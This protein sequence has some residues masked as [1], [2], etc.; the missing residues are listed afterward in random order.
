MAEIIILEVLYNICSF[1]TYLEKGIVTLLWATIIK[2][3]H[4]L[5]GVPLSLRINGRGFLNGCG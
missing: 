3:P 4:M 5:N 2:K 1:N